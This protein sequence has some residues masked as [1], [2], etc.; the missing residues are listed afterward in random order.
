MSESST[1]PQLS[2]AAVFRQERLASHAVE[3]ARRLLGVVTETEKPEAVVSIRYSSVADRGIDVSIRCT[4][5]ALRSHVEW[6]CSGLGQW[7]AGSADPVEPS[8][9]RVWE[10]RPEYRLAEE[11]RKDTPTTVDDSSVQGGLRP[12]GLFRPAGLLNDFREVVE[13]VRTARAHLRVHVAPA[14]PVELLMAADVVSRSGL[15]VETYEGHLYLGAPVRIRLLV[16]HTATTDVTRVRMQ[17]RKLATGV[18]FVE[19]DAEPETDAA[20]HGSPGSLQGRVEPEAV[21]LAL[22]RLPSAPADGAA[23]FGIPMVAAPVPP[24]AYAGLVPDSGI[25]LGRG[26]TAAGAPLTVLAEPGD[27]LRH[28]QVVGMTGAGKT[29]LLAAVVGSAVEQGYGC[30]VISPHPDLATRVLGEMPA[31]AV[32]RALLVR[33]GDADFPVP[34]NAL[35]HGS[36][37]ALDC[38]LGILQDL[39]DPHHQGMFGMRAQRLLTLGLQA[40]RHVMGE[41]ATIQSAVDVF[42]DKS[43]VTRVAE[44]LREQ[45]PDLARQLDNEVA[46]VSNDNFAE[47]IGWLVSRMQPF[48]GSSYLSAALGTGEDAVDVRSVM[49]ER[50]VLLVDLASTQIGTAPAQLLGELWLIK[51][52][53]ALAQRKNRRPHLLVV[54]ECQLF[55]AGTLPRLIAEG[56]KFGIG[57]VVAH[58]HMA[59]LDGRLAEAVKANASSLVAFRCGTTEAAQAAAR[60]GDWSGPPLTRLPNLVAA[61]TLSL[62]SQQT[63]PF[64]L[65]VDHNERCRFD[66][67]QERAAAR[68]S[69][70]RLV[71]PYLGLARQ[72]PASIRSEVERRRSASQTASV[73][74]PWLDGRSALRKETA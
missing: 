40:A 47:L 73:L 24:V 25:R 50:G 55:A 16:G 38:I 33:S 13:A 62:A 6:A 20:W 9:E 35:R 32:D 27:L 52:W 11:T 70:E 29:S 36:E 19:L 22:L 58:Q 45:D 17:L 59:Q 39:L 4:D 23:P 12:V 57:C 44:T 63:E 67:D 21:A 26:T 18:R 41:R 61:A 34:L 3:A 31:S 46:S 10:V 69:R 71:Q 60:L 54:D 66:E 53:D 74:G 51:H 37:V 43:F 14:T 2:L 68:H 28:M 72:T 1:G 64:T 56:R 8:P 49:D 48:L 15:P 5:P 65:R 7:T 42:Q 30:S